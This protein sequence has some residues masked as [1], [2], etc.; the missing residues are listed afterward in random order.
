MKLLDF[1]TTQSSI[2]KILIEAIKEMIAEANLEFSNEGIRIVKMD[3]TDTICVSLELNAE[4]FRESGHYIC[5]HTKE[6][7][8][9]VGIS[10]VYLYK[11]LKGIDN[12][13]ILSFTVS[14]E[15]R[16]VL[17]IKIENSAK[18]SV[19]KLSLNLI[20]INEE[21][22]N[23]PE[24]E[25]DTVITYNS[26]CFQKIIKE[27]NNLRIKYVDI[28]SYNKQLIF[29]GTGEITNY[30]EDTIDEDLQNENNVVP[31]IKFQVNSENTIC[32]GEYQTSQLMSITKFTNLS[33]VVTLKMKND[34]PLF[35]NYSVGSLGKITIIVAPRA[36][37]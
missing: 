28:K 13:D 1:K 4:N 7:P 34:V 11:L 36:D 23:F 17:D 29:S 19:K 37:N 30:F 21:N 8:L 27:M 20:E 18:A 10:I 31:V 2:I 15:N 33:N 25:F 16:N 35:I 9:T 14:E 3:S 26:S 24:V 22:L 32:Q 12:D 6:S 5:N